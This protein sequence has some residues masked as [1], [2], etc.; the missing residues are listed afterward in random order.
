MITALG[1]TKVNGEEVTRTKTTRRRRPS[2]G[3]AVLYLFAI[4]AALYSLWPLMVM[5]LE[6]YDI[7][8]SVVFVGNA[9]RYVFNIPYYSGGIF[10]TPIHYL[11]AL[12]FGGFPRLVENSLIIALISI[13]IALVVGIPIA[14]ILAGSR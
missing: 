10:P 12:S 5:A 9:V 4:L 3:R 7:D 14:Y 1:T 11:D 8:L 6:G 13:A 2:I